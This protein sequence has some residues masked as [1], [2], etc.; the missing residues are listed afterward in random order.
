MSPEAAL[1]NPLPSSQDR[2]PGTSPHSWRGQR[3]ARAGPRPRKKPGQAV[4]GP[5]QAPLRPLGLSSGKRLGASNSFRLRRAEPPSL[6]LEPHS[7]P[8]ARVCG[9]EGAGAGG[10]AFAPP[11]RSEDRGPLPAGGRGRSPL[12]SPPASPGLNAAAASAGSSRL[13]VPTSGTQ[14]APLPGPAARVAAPVGSALR[15]RL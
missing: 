12:P 13:A 9:S 1:L 10:A 6:P 3:R 2:S 8:A 7:S 4:G 5:S 11:Q 15:P 14:P